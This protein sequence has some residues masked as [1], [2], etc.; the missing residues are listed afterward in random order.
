MRSPTKTGRET[1]E[2]N[3]SIV[4][5]SISSINIRKILKQVVSN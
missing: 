4:V 5:S 2:S 1:Q 3:T